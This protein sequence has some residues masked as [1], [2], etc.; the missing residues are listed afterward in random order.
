MIDIKDICIIQVSIIYSTFKKQETKQRAPI[1][2]MTGAPIK[3]N[4]NIFIGNYFKFLRSWTY[5]TR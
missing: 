1:V 5:K 2:D 3:G 4:N